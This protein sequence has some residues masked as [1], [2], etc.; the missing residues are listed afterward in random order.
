MMELI[1]SINDTSS[2]HPP[3]DNFVQD[4]YGVELLES[5]IHY[6]ETVN[7]WS[8]GA[9]LVVFEED[10]KLFIVDGDEWEPYEVT[11]EEA[12][13]DMLDFEKA[14]SLCRVTF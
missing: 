6:A 3:I 1:Q 9:I 5:Q 8:W 7:D 2:V 4:F 10:G 14:I 12:L 11:E 13:R